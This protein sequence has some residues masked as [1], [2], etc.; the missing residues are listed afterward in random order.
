MFYPQAGSGA[1]PDGVQINE[2]SQSR[3]AMA[4]C[5]AK[6]SLQHPDDIFGRHPVEGVVLAG[7]ID[8]PYRRR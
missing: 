5:G 1:S 6:I 4:G 7:G 8:G 2:R 3:R